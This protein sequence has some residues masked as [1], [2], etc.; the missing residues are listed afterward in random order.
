M[1]HFTG[2]IGK[3]GFLSNFYASSFTYKGIHFTNSEA[4]FQSQKEPE[5]AERYADRPPS[6]A[7]SMGRSANLRP[8]WEQ[9]KDQVM[10]DV[11]Y[12]KFT[13][14]PE[15]KEALLETGDETLVEVTTWHDRYWGI[16]TCPNC[17]GVGR[18]Q[19]GYT[20]MKLRNDFKEEN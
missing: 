4:A 19:L 7:K 5:N 11:L 15:L 1:I 3:Y 13:Q 2:N 20:L 14:N 9:V 6:F 10:Y 18:N 16:C 17:R 8:D 12:A